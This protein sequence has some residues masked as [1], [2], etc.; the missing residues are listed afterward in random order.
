MSV[1]SESHHFRGVLCRRCGKPVRL[2]ELVTKREAASH[3][4]HDANDAEFHLVSKVFVLRC[5]AC[6][7]ESIYALNQI[8]DCA[9]V[10]SPSRDLAKQAS[11]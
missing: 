4:H 6:S 7:K 9:P 10:F 11:M 3:V 8:V 5:R 1:E 2:P